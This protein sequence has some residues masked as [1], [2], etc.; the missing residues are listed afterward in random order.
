MQAAPGSEKFALSKQ[1]LL[2]GGMV[3]QRTNIKAS[4]ADGNAGIGQLPV[5]GQ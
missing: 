5:A 1:Q 4:K 3:N 2:L